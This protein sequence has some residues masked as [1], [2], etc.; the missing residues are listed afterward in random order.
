VA[1]A[2]RRPQLGRPFLSWGTLA[3]AVAVAAF[4]GALVGN[5]VSSRRY[6]QHEPS[7][8]DILERRLR[9]QNARPP[10]LAAS[11]TGGAG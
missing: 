10:S 1:T 8:W 6:R 9:E 3:V 4:V 11:R 5:T 7:I 2:L